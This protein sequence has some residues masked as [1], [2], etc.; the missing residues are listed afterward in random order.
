MKLET[1]FDSF[2]NDQ[3]KQ[4]AAQIKQYRVKKF[5]QEYPAWLEERFSNAS[6]YKFLKD[7][8]TCIY[9]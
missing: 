8:I 5:F 6:A 2:I 1:I 7:A 4:A 9:H 3:R